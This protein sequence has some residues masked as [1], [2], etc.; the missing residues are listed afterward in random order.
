[1]RAPDLGKPGI[2]DIN[3]GTYPGGEV[4]VHVRSSRPFNRKQLI[5]LSTC[6]TPARPWWAKLELRSG[7]VHRSARL[8]QATAPQSPPRAPGPLWKA[9]RLAKA[10]ARW[11]YRDSAE[12]RPHT[13]HGSGLLNDHTNWLRPAPPEPRTAPTKS[14]TTFVFFFLPKKRNV[15]VLFVGAVLARAG[16]GVASWC[17]R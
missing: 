6:S 8:A 3:V 1:M 16:P 4:A 9:A 14:T 10:P 5:V 15:V 17:D 13:E 12:A 11:E 2:E 7:P